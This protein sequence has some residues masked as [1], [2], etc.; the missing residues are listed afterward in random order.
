MSAFDEVVITVDAQNAAPV[1]NA[2]ADQIIA[3]PNVA[4]LTGSATDDALPRGS[5]LTYAW[6]GAAGVT[7][8]DAT[9]ASTTSTFAAPGVYTL[10]LTVSDGALTA[11]DEVVITVDAENAAPVVNA[12]AD[13]IIAL[14]NVA[15]LTGSSTDDALPR[16]SSLTYAWSGP[17]GVTFGDSA[18]ASTTATFAAPGVYTLRL[19]VSD[20]ALSAF[21]DVTITAN[22]VIVNHAPE[23]QAGDDQ[24]IDFGAT[25]SLTGTIDDDGL[26]QGAAVTAAWS[27]ISGPGVV[28]FADSSAASTTA[29]FSVAGTYVLRLTATDTEL[30]ATDDITVVVHRLP[31]ASFTLAGP[32]RNVALSRNDVASIYAGAKVIAV[33]SDVGGSFNV[34]TALD[35]DPNS[36][37][38]TQYGQNANQSFTVALFGDAPVTF[39]RIRILN[40]VAGLGISRFRVEAS[41]TTSDPSAFTTIL[42]GVLTEA[43][44]MQDFPLTR[45]VSARFLRFLAI[46]NHGASQMWLRTFSAIVTDRP[47]IPS[48]EATGNV[49]SLPLGGAIVA[50]SSNT[51]EG[52]RLLDGNPG[53]VWRGD[54]PAN[55]W[56]IAELGQTSTIDRI[57]LNN[58]S[59]SRGIRHFRVGVATSD[60]LSFTTVLDATAEAGSAV[61]E[62]VLP[63][64]PVA[65]HYLRID[66]LDNQGDPLYTS[67]GELQVISSA[68][69]ISAP[70]YAD[71][72]MPDGILDGAPVATVWSVTPAAPAYTVIRV[73]SDAPALVDSVLLQALGT[74]DTIVK[75]FDVLVSDTSDEPAAFHNV[76]SATYVNNTTA[77]IFTFPAGAVRARYVKLVLK[78]NYGSRDEI[79]LGTFQ[80]LTPRADGNIISSPLPPPTLHPDVVAVSSSRADGPAANAVDGIVS[81]MWLTETGAVTDQWIKLAMPDGAIRQLFGV[82][83]DANGFSGPREFEIR[84]STTTADDAA[85]TTV[86]SGVSAFG[87]RDFL[88]AGD[89]PAKYVEFF[90]KN[91][92]STST[93]TAGELRL[94][95]LPDDGATL[96]DVSSAS[97]RS[98]RTGVLD[99]NFTND[100]WS[101]AEGEATNQFI[102]VALPAAHPW[103]ID[104]VA[105]QSVPCCYANAPREFLIQ[106]ADRSEGPF[107]TVLDAILPPSGV[108]EY[109][110]FTPVEARYVRLV[111]KDNWGGSFIELNTFWVLS[112]QSGTLEPR[113]VDTSGR[114]DADVAR[115][116]W[117]FGD[118]TTSTERDPLHTYGNPGTYDVTLTVTDAE[119][120]TSRRTIAYTAIGVA[121]ADF[122]ITPSPGDEGALIVFTDTSSTSFGDIVRSDWSFGDG[123]SVENRLS[124]GHRYADNGVYTV[125]HTVT[126]ARGAIS[127]VKKTVTIR[128]VAPTANAGPD[129]TFYRLENWPMQSTLFS[130]PGEIDVQS[131]RCEWDFGDGNH[132]TTGCGSAPPH[133]YAAAGTYTV[134]LTVIDKDG[135]SGT[136]TAQYTVLRRIPSLVYGGARAVV[137]NQP[138][139]LRA[140][141]RDA[142][143]NLP[144]AG[145]TITFAFGS[146]RVSAVTDA[147]GAAVATIVY[148]GAEF[149]ASVSLSFDGDADYQAATGS[150][151]IA[152]SEERAIDAVLV[153]DMSDSMFHGVGEVRAASRIFIDSLN[154]ASD[155]AGVVMF[156]SQVTTLAPLSRDFDA[157]RAAVDRFYTCCATNLAG[158]INVAAQMLNGPAHTPDA[159]KVIVLISDG[160]ADLQEAAIA[161]DAAHA[162]GIRIISVIIAPGPDGVPLMRRIASSTADYYEASLW[163]D[164]RSIYVSLVPSLCEIANQPPVALAGD[165]QRIVAPQTTATLNAT[166][167]D[168]GLPAGAPVTVKWSIVSGPGSVTFANDT[169]ATT[170]ASFGALGLYVLRVTA[171]DSEYTRSSDVT[172]A[173]EPVNQAPMVP[174]GAMTLTDPAT[175][176]TLNANATDDGYPLRHALTYSWSQVSG[177]AQATLATPEW[178][179]T[180]AVLPLHGVYIFRVAVSDSL[181]TTVG[182]ITVTYEAVNAAPVVNA[183]SDATI[184][185][186]QRTATLHGSAT[187]DGLPTAA[188]LT[189]AWSQVSGPA[190]ASLAAADSATTDV[191]LPTHG[192]YVFR[193]TVSDSKL[194]ASDDVQITYDGTNAAP[195]VDAGADQTIALPNTAT[196]SAAITDDRLPLDSALTAQWSQVSGPASVTFASPA[197]ATTT[198]S[199]TAAGT[200]VLRITATD[201]ALAASDDITIEVTPALP[202]AAVAIT[203]PDS[204]S[205]ITDRTTIRGTVTGAAEWRLEY[206][207]ASDTPSDAWTALAHGTEP[208]SDAAAGI[209]DPTAA[210]N[211][212]YRVRLTATTAA[213]Q[214]STSTIVLTVR[215]GLKI[216]HFSLAFTDLVV[217]V[218]GLPIEL[219]RSYDS[220][221]TQKGDFGIGWT[222]RTRNLRL[223]KSGTMGSGWEE[224]YKADP[225]FPVYCLRPT[226]PR[227][228]TIT[229]AN[230]NVYKFM[231]QASP[232]CQQVTPIQTASLAFVPVEGTTGSLSAVGGDELV[233]NGAV[234]GAVELLTGSAEV[235]DPTQFR[236]T[237]ENG[238]VYSIDAASGVTSIAEANGATVSFGHDG[239]VHSAGK[240]VAF[241]RDAEDR[242]T[243]VTDPTGAEAHYAYDA[244]GDLISYTN[245]AGGVTSFTYDGAHHLQS[246]QGPDGAVAVRYEYDDAG[247]LLR[248]ID[249]TGH[250][251]ELDHDFTGH[252]EVITDRL[253]YA[254]INEYDSF[255]NVVK[256]VDAEG[257]VTTRTFDGNGNKLTET[258]ALGKTTTYT[259]DA[260]NHVTSVTDPSGH[261]TE[262]TY[263]ARGQLLTTTDPTGAVKTNTYDARGNLLSITTPSGTT[264]TY[265]VTPAGNI[266]SV[267]R[268]GHLIATYEYDAAGN[269]T[270]ESDATGRVVLS[271]YDANGHATKK[272][273]QHHEGDTTRPVAISYVVD[274]EGRVTKTTYPD[275]STEQQ[276]YDAVGNVTSRTARD[277]RTTHYDY[278]ALGHVIKTTYADGKAEENVYDAEGRVTKSTDA[279]GASKS[280]AYD[281]VGRRIATTFADGTSI[282][283][284]WDAAGQLKSFRDAAGATTTFS[285]D[286]AGRRTAVSDVTGAVTKFGY[287]AAGRE[288]AVTDPLGAT[289][290]FAYDADG[291]LIRTVH[292]GGASESV[293][294]DGRG[295]VV[296][297]TDA[298]GKTTRFS[299]DDADQL[300]ETQDALGGRT[301][302]TYDDLGLLI[303]QTDAAGRVTRHQYDDMGRRTRRTLP[304]GQSE[305]L[306]Y[307][308]AG[309]PVAKTDFNG[310]TT[311]YT[312]DERGR[313]LAKI[314]DPRLSEPQVSFT[315]DAV[316]NRASMTDATGTTAYTYDTMNRLTAKATPFGTLQ[317]EYDASGRLASMRS[318]HVGGLSMTYAYDT[319]G[320]L[321]GATDSVTGTTSYTWNAAGLPSAI[322]YAN[323]MTTALTFDPR[324][325]LTDV[326]INTPQDAMAYHYELAPAGNRLSVAETSGR[327]VQYA[328]DDLDRLTAESISGDPVASL[329]GT[330][331]YSFDAVSNR[332]SR[333]STISAV[334]SQTFGYDANDRVTGTEYDA[335]G[336]T[337][338]SGSNRYQYD[339]EDHLIDVNGTAQF[340]YDGDGNRVGR[341]EVGV[342]TYF[343]I[344]SLNPTGQP[345]VVEEI[346]GG[347]VTTVYSYG[348][349]RISQRRIDDQGANAI[350]YYAYDGQSGVR[351]LTGATGA[352]SDTWRYDA[353]GNLLAATGSTQNEMLYGGEQ[354]DPA[355][356]LYYQ[357]A[358]FYD[359][360]LG[361]FQTMDTFEGSLQDPRSLHKYDY[362]FANPATYH[363]PT[364]H[365]A[366]LMDVESALAIGHTLDELEVNVM[367]GFKDALLDREFGLSDYF[368]LVVRD[369]ALAAGVS[370]VGGYVGSLVTSIGSTRAP[371]NYKNFREFKAA[372]RGLS[373]KEGA[374]LDLELATAWSAYLST[375]LGDEVIVIGRLRETRILA[376]ST[377]FNVQYIPSGIDGS[378][379][380]TPL[381]NR[382]W[383][384]GGINR[385]ARFLN[386]TEP[387][388]AAL[389]TGGPYG[390]SVWKTELDQLLLAGYTGQRDYLLPK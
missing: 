291:R 45:P 158:G 69:R 92:Y 168:D 324:H 384:A 71:G 15:T 144:L 251:T 39:D 27:V 21:D 182:D 53:T 303:A 204:G 44:R 188:V 70:S 55:E 185:D 290:T 240:G 354:Y 82:G 16:G 198:V 325:R 219:I 305:S 284:T 310:H 194:S 254:T 343:L 374:E 123:Q 83:I 298:D 129:L 17:A 331:S 120:R 104:G 246:I 37:W 184:T 237:L 280:I 203:S 9:A 358:R 329:N 165:D 245:R 64:G 156:Q 200:Y 317:Y 242:I 255:G 231:A 26:P 2:G 239:I 223:Q 208:L 267:T 287:D 94:Y 90:W 272:T 115:Y 31:S 370:L 262:S 294:Y 357:R 228:V 322:Q 266:A 11:F 96:V 199:F 217:P 224:T 110:T 206:Q 164:L 386:V 332:L 50:A 387:T 147:N 365:F 178:A 193:L 84:V 366:S 127:N 318:S 102:T 367:M 216:G 19:T 170:T 103:I 389:W 67:F 232:M 261:R 213:G 56:L 320:R 368:M 3:L 139:A 241:T 270:K 13:Q 334:P 295:R 122:T 297:K 288:T 49:A 161:A 210:L 244:T 380:W 65:A 323:G 57:R 8:G 54:R 149:P 7:F 268:D 14:P 233:V 114:G 75:D 281:H 97:S 283:Q 307:D 201:G 73:T 316:G 191:Q 383:I 338:A 214:V 81:T 279:A 296:A 91:G 348:L 137:A 352:I 257:G 269:R 23:V 143:I 43:N 289:T 308:A 253:G 145:R 30:T 126:N 76:L 32:T 152:C 248:Q 264:T 148:D 38:R 375:N 302:F 86:Y 36:G 345:Q 197:V 46:D 250:V 385:G 362:A 361:R 159:T 190:A 74:T 301:R 207:P 371:T 344:D 41:S 337:I 95:T 377:D 326:A 20:G 34:G 105:L 128:N 85:F 72:G 24:S 382:A 277:G 376:G 273:F 346:A 330:I 350:S 150:A 249:A 171:S 109:F 360:S 52:F 373:S 142:D 299:Y 132:A 180:G 108:H 79:R 285:Y 312:Y 353:F 130:E 347:R 351:A 222:L 247:R 162:A 229:F 381:V 274:P 135:G 342:T 259:Y 286:D 205:T 192:R 292:P 18:A 40:G 173:V 306:V 265:T 48:Y 319:A 93:I 133:A 174:G 258:N 138:V 212:I 271:E 98:S 151:K 87:A 388:Q 118:G 183:G 315:Y 113:F 333:T 80:V 12:G 175:T 154:P 47:G 390:W 29:T 169:S 125:T 99:A 155:Q 28:A 58:S 68:T 356:S 153:A 278:D 327:K 63:G 88:F 172:I 33:T 160:E 111:A 340:L 209:F 238:I 313:L 309:R 226:Q 59:D 304:L 66:L 321:I 134:T 243:S 177:P 234:P 101:T 112:P 276:T 282:Q 363:D 187:D 195:V 221:D 51:G 364:G 167:T 42:T 215:G 252:R 359:P 62:F 189:Y 336:N 119:N 275:G 335:N 116:D 378:D 256:V 379:L 121:A 22:A 235:F 181:L 314:P 107:R 341:S 218:S 106:V 124:Q 260:Q 89:V 4:T 236:L 372:W 61:Q 230:G 263:N 202:P 355:S 60:A 220:F 140:V 186:P 196:V 141:L 311:H 163:S 117:D 5:S 179:T 166:I 25:A 300:I 78:N 146:Q 35:G 157:A 211:G 227:F 1:V 349:Q 6:S 225:L 293:A 339:F 328:Y 77:Q 131:L 100:G 136:D 176:A 10:R 369:Y